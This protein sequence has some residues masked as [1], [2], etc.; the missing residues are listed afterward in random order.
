MKEQRMSL[1]INAAMPWFCL[2][3]HHLLI[4]D[5]TGPAFI[6]LYL[7]LFQPWLHIRMHDKDAWPT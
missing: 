3:H 7:L 5:D 1:D 4:Y 2:V 6:I